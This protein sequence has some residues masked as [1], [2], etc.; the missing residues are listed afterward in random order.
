MLYAVI[1]YFSPA[2]VSPLSGDQR[3]Y[4]LSGIV[5]AT[6]LIPALFIYMLYQFKAID[7]LQLDNQE[8]RTLPLL[9]TT[10]VYGSFTYF[11]ALQLTSL[12]AIY[13]ILGSITVAVGLVMLINLFW[14]ISA[15]SVGISGVVGSLIGINQKFG[16]GELF[17]PILVSIPVAGLLMSA[18]LALNAHSPAQI[19]AGCL[20]GL[21]ISLGTV[22]W[23]F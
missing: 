2:S 20:L 8:E 6:F 16:G 22:Y 1:F 23:F 13:V 14:K 3:L 9:V 5:V 10:V 12:T 18:R 17:Y 19:L 4:M 11:F 21:S 15:H 7:N